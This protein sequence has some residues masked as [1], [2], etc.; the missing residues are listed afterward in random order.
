MPEKILCIIWKVTN[1]ELEKNR[2][3]RKEEKL[4]TKNLSIQFK[5]S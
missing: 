5:K 2:Y 3:N 4:K 1:A